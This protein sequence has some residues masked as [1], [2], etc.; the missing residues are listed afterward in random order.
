MQLAL[1]VKRPL[2]VSRERPDDFYHLYYDEM[3]ADPFGQIRKIYK[4]L[5]D[6]LSPEAKALLDRD[7]LTWAARVLRR[8]R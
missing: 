4:W 3:M 7:R 8:Q 2:E 6:D 5:G 1:H